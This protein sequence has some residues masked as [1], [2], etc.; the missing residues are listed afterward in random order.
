[1]EANGTPDIYEHN[2]ASHPKLFLTKQA[3][4]VS[5]SVRYLLFPFGNHGYQMIVPQKPK[6][7]IAD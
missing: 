6:N 2:P 7:Y 1:M 4:N 5:H 3:E